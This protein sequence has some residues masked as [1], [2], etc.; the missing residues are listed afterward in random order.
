MFRASH[1]CWFNEIYIIF[2]VDVCFW[3]H[4]HKHMSAHFVSR[5]LSFTARNT[6]Q[7]VI[8]YS[9]HLDLRA[10]KMFS[11]ASMH[12]LGFR[13]DISI[14]LIPQFMWINANKMEDLLVVNKLKC[15]ELWYPHIPWNIF[16]INSPKIRRL[17]CLNFEMRLFY[18][19]QWF[20]KQFNTRN[21]W[22]T[23]ECSGYFG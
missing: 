5:L 23:C 2:I 4:M 1:Q 16:S 21:K 17:G 13:A 6:S 14:Y 15:G 9:Q 22:Q 11:D 7:H 3:S 20:Q 12:T 19:R 8:T 18:C 10:G